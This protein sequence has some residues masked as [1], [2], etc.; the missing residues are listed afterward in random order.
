VKVNDL[1]KELIDLPGDLPV[2]INVLYPM[3]GSFLPFEMAKYHI[4]GVERIGE[5]ATLDYDEEDF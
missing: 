3:E 2:V 5:E 1:L 4:V